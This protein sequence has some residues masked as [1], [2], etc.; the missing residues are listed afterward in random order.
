MAA[1]TIFMADTSSVPPTLLPSIC[2]LNARQIEMCVS[3]RSPTKL[4]FLTEIAVTV[5]HGAALTVSYDD[6]L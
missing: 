2:Y 4:C 6:D 5:R 3:R 1:A